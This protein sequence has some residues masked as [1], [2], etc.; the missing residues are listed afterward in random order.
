MDLSISATH[1]HDWLTTLNRAAQAL[2][3]YPK[4]SEVREQLLDVL[5]STLTD[6]V[7]ARRE[8]TLRIRDGAIDLGEETVLRDDDE[9][10]F[11]NILFSGS[12]LELSFVEGV[13]RP[14]LAA[15]LETVLADYRRASAD[16]EELATALWRLELPHIQYKHVDLLSIAVLG[17]R[18]QPHQ[19]LELDDEHAQRLKRDI[20]MITGALA[21]DEHT[22][23]DLVGVI[24]GPLRTPADRHRA[25]RNAQQ[26]FDDTADAARGAM[27]P[28][29]KASLALELRTKNTHEEIVV[30]L[31]Q[32]LCDA[33]RRESRPHDP[34]AA[35]ELL[36]V[37]F[38]GIVEARQFDDAGRIVRRLT[39]VA[40]GAREV[41]QVEF[42][43]RFLVRFGRKE[44]IQTAVETLMAV[45]SHGRAKVLAYLDALERYAV[46]HLLEEIDRIETHEVRSEICELIVRNGERRLELIVER[47]PTMRYEVAAAILQSSRLMSPDAGSQLV[48]PG[49]IHDHPQVRAAAVQ[50]LA[51]FDGRAAQRAAIAALDDESDV[52]V[53]AA[54]RVI[55]RRQILDART[56]LIR[57]LDGDRLRESEPRLAGLLLNAYASLD[58]DDAIPRIENIARAAGMLAA[59]RAT[60]LSLAAVKALATLDGPAVVEALDRVART[61]NAKVRRA[62]QE[63]SIQVQA[64]A[65]RPR[66]EPSKT[67][68]PNLEPRSKRAIELLPAE[69]API[70]EET[71]VPALLPPE[72]LTPMPEVAQAKHAAYAA[73][74]TLPERT[75][76]IR[77]PSDALIPLI[78]AET[79]LSRAVLRLEVP[80]NDGDEE[81]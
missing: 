16:G 1:V 18:L 19:R 40:R 30:H 80:A 57:I 7:G 3:F 58:G 34:S 74:L 23:M 78:E 38:D 50:A 37:V 68:R 69:P 46:P 44:H 49:L 21:V 63:A 10:A 24:D 13:T 4:G 48:W 11:G 15:L 36:L 76:P 12:I 62:A 42:A 66:S 60:T 55:Q 41:S 25:S 81:E 43:H 29:A 61:R 9:K 31:V 56:T 52:V 14:E 27:D 59:K 51:M 54:L 2:R 35:L 65:A 28:R 5:H 72:F 71:E 67:P 39:T 79:V 17:E 53:T 8:L 77:L 6:I 64:K 32:L 75:P 33:L 47:I 22:G 70:L 73:D 20:D 26:W 45:D